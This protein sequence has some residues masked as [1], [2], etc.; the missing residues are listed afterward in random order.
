MIR[1]YIVRYSTEPRNQIYVQ[2]YGF[3]SFVKKL[4]N[5]LSSK[6]GPKVLDTTKDITNRCTK[7]C[8]RKSNPKNSRR[9]G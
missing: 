1:V 5:I 8:I 2:S 3:F 6:F 9:N 4:G 7:N